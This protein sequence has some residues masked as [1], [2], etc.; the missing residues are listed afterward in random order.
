M[1]KKSIFQ[2]L[3][4]YRVKVERDGK[5]IINIP[6]IFCLPGLLIAPKMSIAGLVAAPLLGC[7]IHLESEDGQ[8]A[9][10]EKTVRK[11]AEA[12]METANTAVKTVREEMEKAWQDLSAEDEPET[13]DTAEEPAREN[14]S[15]P[16]SA[17]EPEKEKEIPTIHVNPDDSTQ[18]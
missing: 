1:E 18:P 13:E 10:L 14:A 9:D 6:G 8:E 3:T 5:E 7:S 12:V 17:E 16:E 2:E 4:D 15:D 11:A